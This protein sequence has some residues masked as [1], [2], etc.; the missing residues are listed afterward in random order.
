MSEPRRTR[1]IVEPA[2]RAE[3]RL[4]RILASGWR[5][6]EADLERLAADAATIGGLGLSQLAERIRQVS[7]GPPTGRLDRAALALAACRLA[8]AHLADGEPPA[9]NWE[10]IALQTRRAALP[11]IVPL[12]RLTLDEGEVWTA[13]RVSGSASDLILVEPIPLNA[14]PWFGRPIQGAL[15]WQARYPLGTIGDV[16]LATLSQP[17]Q[18]HDDHANPDRMADFRQAVAAGKIAEGLS[19][20]AWIGK[21]QVI[22]LTPEFAST[23][24]W[25]HPSAARAFAALARG[26]LWTVCWVDGSIVVP[27]VAIEPPGFFQSARL[28]H[29]IEGAPSEPFPV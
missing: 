5:N 13:I 27:L 7:A 19:V 11:R 3:A 4:E 22:R 20:L 25:L 15:S 1:A 23:C 24:V 29:L 28:I 6:A 9:G 18:S 16:Q 2:R 12:G 26:D 10:P 21:F 17:R 14:L 8:R